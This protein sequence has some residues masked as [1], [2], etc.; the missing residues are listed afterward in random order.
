[1]LLTI[2]IHVKILIISVLFSEQ[3]LGRVGRAGHLGVPAGTMLA[4]CA[5]GEPCW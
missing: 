5:R 4:W 2:F 1:M 3:A